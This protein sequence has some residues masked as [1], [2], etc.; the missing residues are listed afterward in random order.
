M[1]SP[2]VAINYAY[3]GIYNRGF[4]LDGGNVSKHLCKNRKT[5]MNS[6]KYFL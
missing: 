2:T 6:R 4:H 5:P 3:T 1:F